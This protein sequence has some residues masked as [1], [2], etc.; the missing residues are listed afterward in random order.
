MAYGSTSRLIGDLPAHAA[1]RRTTIIR[2][3]AVSSVSVIANLVELAHYR[4]LLYTLTLHRIKVR[5]KQSVL[6]VSWAIIQP[7]SMTVIFAAIF[8]LLVRM[9]SDGAPYLIFAYVALLPWNCFS[10][11]VSNG[12]GGLVSHS[13]LV[14]KVYFPREILPATYILAALFDFVIG[15]SVLGVLLIWY[16]IPLSFNAAYVVPIM[17]VLVLFSIA[18]ALFASATQ[19]RFRDIGL[20]VPL[21]LQLWMFATPVVYPMSVVPSKLR[22]LYVL[23]PM[24]GIIEN[25]RRVILP[26]SPP[27]PASLGAAAAVSVSLLI[28]A[29]IYFKRVEATMADVI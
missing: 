14:T 7:L 23:N 4:D 20:A 15:V 9:P 13:Q 29:Y 11:S 8:S 3:P 27:D 1:S 18:S 10:A 21:L 26:G 6:G 28:A 2:P 5:Y 17:L 24:A 22:S 16:R 25:F 19:V 12:T